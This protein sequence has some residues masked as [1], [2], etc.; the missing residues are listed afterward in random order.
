MTSQRSQSVES[1]TIILPSRTHWR[2]G[3]GRKEPHESGNQEKGK[4]TSERSQSIEI[5]CDGQKRELDYPAGSVSRPIA[6][7]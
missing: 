3:I 4:M 5:R 1:S 6:L 2:Y 7:L